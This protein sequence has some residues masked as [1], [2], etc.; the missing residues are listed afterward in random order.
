[1]KKN[2]TYEQFKNK[3]IGVVPA[4]SRNKREIQ[5][6]DVLMTLT[7]LSSKNWCVYDDGRFRCD[8]SKDG[9]NYCIW[10]M[11]ENLDGQDKETKYFLCNILEN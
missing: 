1:M 9:E 7:C 10:D 11:T 3:I 4:I 2:M 8:E 6:A 5:L